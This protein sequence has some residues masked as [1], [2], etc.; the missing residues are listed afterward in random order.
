MFMNY[1][2]NNTTWVVVVICAATV[3]RIAAVQAPEGISYEHVAPL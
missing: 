1:E 3:T 2:I